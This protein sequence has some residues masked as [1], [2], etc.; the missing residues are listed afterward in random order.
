MSCFPPQKQ[1]FLQKS[2]GM[3][4]NIL[5]SSENFHKSCLGVKNYNPQNKFPQTS[6]IL[7]FVKKKITENLKISSSEKEVI[8]YKK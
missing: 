5:Y 6:A 4:K 1:K 8:K 7:T 2:F 3:A